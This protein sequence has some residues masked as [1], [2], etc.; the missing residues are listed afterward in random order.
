MTIF[1]FQTEANPF[2]GGNA[3]FII[4]PNPYSHTTNATDYLDLTTWFNFVVSDNG[5]FDSDPMPGIIELVGVNNGTY[6]I[7]QI[8]GTAG[9]GTAVYPVASDEILG[10]TGFS[11]VIQTFVN[12]TTTTSTTVEPPLISDTIYDKLK[13]TGGAKING[14]AI[15]SKNDLPP[16]KVVVASQK[17][18]ATPPDHVVFTQTFSTSATPSTLIS[19]LGIPTYS[20]PTDISSGTSTVFIPPVYVAPVASNGGNFILTPVMDTIVPGSNIVIRADKVSQ[21]SDHPMLESIELP[22]NTQGSNVGISVKVDDAIPSSSPSIPSGFAKIYLDF[23]TSGDIDFSNPNVYTEDP[24]IR[25]TLEKVGSDC[26]TGVTLYLQQGSSWST[27]GSSLSPSSTGTHTCT[28]SKTVDHFSSYLV[29]TGNTSVHTHGDS[30]HS[31]SHS[32]THD[33]TSHDGHSGHSHASLA[34]HEPGDHPYEHAILQITKQLTIY[35]IQYSLETGTAQIIIG[36]AGS[37]DDIEVQV[38]ARKTGLFTAKLAKMNP[39]ELFNKQSHG[40]LNKYVFEFP[41]DPNET[42]FRVSVDDAKYTLAQTVNID[43]IRGKVVPWYADA[44]ESSDHL[45]HDS[46][47]TTSPT[48]Y[49]TKF[50]GGTKTVSYNDVQFPIKYEMAGAISGI[51]VDETSKSVTF[52]LSEISGGIATIQIPRSLVDA[53]GDNFIILVTASPQEQ[54]NYQIISSTSDHYTLQMDLPEGASSLTVVGTAVVPE[55]GF[56]APLVLSL[57]II[58]IVISKR[59]RF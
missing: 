16:A 34:E 26:P 3:T 10:T 57:A 41:L 28:Y 25:F 11:Y 6:G 30:S 23:Q 5:Q 17:L 39:F 48:E 37:L 15:S 18:T 32:S 56:L 45:D 38:H 9:F 54:I 49:S 40:D 29:G 4:T 42:Y 21:G 1:N 20:P 13:N 19:T 50:D 51:T 7:M 53:V 35:E 47:V 59:F 52:L 43:G 44:S 27:V 55:F 14:V 2:L 24:T 22:M 58:P 8:K 12:F 36:T 33:S 31:S 46:H